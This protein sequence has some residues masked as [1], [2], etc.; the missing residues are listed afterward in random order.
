MLDEFELKI[1]DSLVAVPTF[2]FVEAGEGDGKSML[3]FGVDD[4][5][6]E[7]SSNKSSTED[8]R[9]RFFV[10]VLHRSALISPDFGEAFDVD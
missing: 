8:R 9:L 2:V 10:S 1:D 6:A 7:R 3:L 5:S 4:L